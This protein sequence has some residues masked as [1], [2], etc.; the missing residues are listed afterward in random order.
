M[1]VLVNDDACLEVAIPVRR[2]GRPQVHPHARHGT[3]RRSG[4]VLV[5][6]GDQRSGR[7][8]LLPG[9]HGVV[10]TLARL[11][12]GQDGVAAP[13]AVAPVLHL[14]VARDLVKAETV[15]QVVVHVGCVE[16]LGDGKV[17]ASCMRELGLDA[18]ARRSE[19]Y[20]YSCG[21]RPR[22]SPYSYSNAI[23]LFSGRKLVSHCD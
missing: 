9:T 23:D 20:T 18:R 11:S 22:G 12:I 17:A 19:T 2:G 5:T 8:T 15:Q 4:K 10:S 13:P 3:V 16:E 21:R 7:V 6:K 14:K 1:A